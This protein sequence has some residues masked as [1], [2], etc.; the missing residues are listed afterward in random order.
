MLVNAHDYTSTNS[1]TTYYCKTTAIQHRMQLHLCELCR[2]NMESSVRANATLCSFFAVRT[3]RLSIVAQAAQQ[4]VLQTH[5]LSNCIVMRNVHFCAMCI[6]SGSSHTHYCMN[7]K[8]S[9]TTNLQI[10][11]REL[12]GMC[13]NHDLSQYY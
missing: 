8:R 5:W 2:E 13:E 1:C 12:F 7:T 10:A 11:D 4:K 9:T 6:S 3:K